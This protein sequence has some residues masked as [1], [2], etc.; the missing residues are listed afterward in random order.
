MQFL[1][2]SSL[3]SFL[4]LL[5]FSLYCSFIGTLQA[6]EQP[7]AAI[8]THESRIERSDTDPTYIMDD[9]PQRRQF[10]A[11]VNEE[12]REA[13]RQAKAEALQAKANASK[14]ESPKESKPEEALDTA[15]K[16]EHT[17]F[18]PSQL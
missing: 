2:Y 5:S 11:K 18:K 16:Q 4:S 10:Q 14:K 9:S 15:Q 8:P 1:R 3:R 6:Q 12:R 7:S 13:K 17:L